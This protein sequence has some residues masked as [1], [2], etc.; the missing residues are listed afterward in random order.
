MDSSRRATSAPVNGDQT[1]GRLM[2][3]QHDKAKEAP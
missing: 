2:V 1:T 3:L